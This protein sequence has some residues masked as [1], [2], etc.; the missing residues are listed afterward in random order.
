MREGFPQG[1]G[2]NIGLL[3]PPD[4]HQN[5]V[6]WTIASAQMHAYTVVYVFSIRLLLIHHATGWGWRIDVKCADQF[7]RIVSCAQNTRAVQT[8]LRF[9]YLGTSSCFLFPMFVWK[10]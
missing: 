3:S 10:D 7:A 4:N 8:T 1:R 2:N 5:A 6:K 9:H